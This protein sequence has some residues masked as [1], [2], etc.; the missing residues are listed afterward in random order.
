[1][2]VPA[3]AGPARGSLPARCPTSSI[4]NGI[5]RYGAHGT[6]H[7]FIA[8]ETA[9]RWAKTASSELNIITATWAAVIRLRHPRTASPST[10]PWG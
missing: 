8:E 10:L 4:A 3:S 2:F 6:L 5:R 1:M 9:R 7:R